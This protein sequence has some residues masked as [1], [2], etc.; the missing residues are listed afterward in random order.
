L[1][2][3]VTNGYVSR[4]CIYSIIISFLEFTAIRS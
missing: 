4:Q 3:E 1:N 2:I